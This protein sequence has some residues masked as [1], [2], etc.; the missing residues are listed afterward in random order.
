MGFRRALSSSSPLATHPHFVALEEQSAGARWAQLLHGDGQDGV[1]GASV[2]CH[3]H[4]LDAVQAVRVQFLLSQVERVAVRSLRLL[5]ASD[6]G[7]PSPPVAWGW[8]IVSL[9]PVLGL[10]VFF[11]TGSG[12]CCSGHGGRA[13]LGLDVQ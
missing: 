1:V 12:S 11:Y 10:G 8:G 4:G 7:R 13:H 2:E 3:V 5:G 6:M 9:G